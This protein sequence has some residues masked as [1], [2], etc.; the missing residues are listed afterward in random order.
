MKTM[1]KTR[2]AVSIPLSVRL[3]SK[4]VREKFLI[5]YELKGCQK[6]LNYLTFYYGVRK[7]RIILNGRR[8]GRN[9]LGW[10]F[11]NKAY[12]KKVGFKRQVILHEV[13]HHL[14]YS[15]RLELPLRTEEKEAN[16]YAKSFNRELK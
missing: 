12:F 2:K 7:M 1:R 10:Y 6:A 14:A 3:P 5:I 11:E 4:R 8:V 15:M 13:Y 9:C 16:A